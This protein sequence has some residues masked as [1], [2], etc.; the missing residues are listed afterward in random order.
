LPKN[1]LF[2]G[3]D[4]MTLKRILKSVFHVS[5]DQAA[6]Y[7]HTH[8]CYNIDVDMVNAVTGI[9][10]NITGDRNENIDSIFQG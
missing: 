4:Y 1:R 5:S 9:T 2:S 6:F 8:A 10:F 3:M 7:G